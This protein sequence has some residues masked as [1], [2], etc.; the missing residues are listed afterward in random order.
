MKYKRF[1]VSLISFWFSRLRQSVCIRGRRPGG[2]FCV[3]PNAPIKAV[4]VKSWGMCSGASL[5]WDTLNAAW[6][7]HG[8]RRI[9][10]DYTN[11]ALCGKVKITYQAL[12]DSGADVVTLSDPAGQSLQYS[13][14]D[15]AAIQQYAQAGHHLIGTYMAFRYDHTDNQGLA[16]LFGIA[17]EVVFQKTNVAVTAAFNQLEPANALFTRLSDPYLSDGCQYTQIP[18]DQSWDAADF[19]GA[20]YV[21]KAGGNR[22]VI[23]VYDAPQYHAIYI[24]TMPECQTQDTYRDLTVF[25]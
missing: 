19:A 9:S 25:V 21:G 2:G 15:M 14:S 16:P 10:I 6:F 18:L 13:A 7:K 5:L 17:P 12:V 8:Y 11:P 3:D 20:R 23:T 22:A 1:L 24:S 4:V